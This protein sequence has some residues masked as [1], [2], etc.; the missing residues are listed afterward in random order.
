MGIYL[1][2]LNQGF[3][4]QSRSHLEYLEFLKTII[5]KPWHAMRIAIQGKLGTICP[6]GIKFEDSKSQLLRIYQSLNP[7]PTLLDDIKQLKK[8]QKEYLQV[9]EERQNSEPNKLKYL[10]TLKKIESC[11]EQAYHFI[12]Q[13]TK[14]LL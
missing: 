7:D 3:V 10:Q 12:D 5:E 2:K 14:S 6:K 4:N 8:I 11:Y 13:N 1:M 9:L